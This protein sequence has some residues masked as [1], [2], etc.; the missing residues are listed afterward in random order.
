MSTEIDS[1][2]SALAS[3]P[4]SDDPA[5]DDPNRA[6]SPYNAA[7]FP[8]SDKPQ[9][10][11]LA[12]ERVQHHIHAYLKKRIS[13]ALTSRSMNTGLSGTIDDQAGYLAGQM[14]GMVKELTGQ[15]SGN[16]KSEEI[17]WRKADFPEEFEFLFTVFRM[18]YQNMDAVHILEKLKA[19]Y[20]VE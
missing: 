20:P 16:Y 5:K 15:T 17:R 11:G 9:M 13:D 12:E 18:R 10:A 19:E 1:K 4:W 6:L 2:K 3:K 14:R 7:V 8:A